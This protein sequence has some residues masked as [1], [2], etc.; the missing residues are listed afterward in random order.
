MTTSLI[1]IQ[2]RYLQL[3]FGPLPDQVLARGVRLAGHLDGPTSEAGSRLRPEDV[4]RHLHRQFYT[5][6]DLD[7]AIQDL[8]EMDRTDPRVKRIHNR[9]ARAAV[10]GGLRLDT[11]SANKRLIKAWKQF[12]KKLQL[13]RPAK[14]HSDFRGLM[15]EGNLPL[16]V[17]LDGDRR[18]AALVRMPT[19]T[20]IPQVGP[21]GRFD[22]PRHAYDQV[23]LAQGGVIGKF[24]LWQLILV[25]LD[26]D[27]FDDLGSLGRPYLDASRTIWRKLSMTEED[28]VIR[29]RMRA[30]LR[31]SHVLEGANQSEME[32]YQH[33]VRSDQADGATTDYFANRK[34]AVTALQ[35]DANLDQIADIEYLLDTF[36]TAAPAPKGLFGY[37]GDLPRDVLEDLKKDYYDELDAMQD[38]LSDAYQ[39][40]FAFDLLLQ[41]IDPERFDHRVQF[42]ERCTETAN[43]RADLALKHQA[44][45]LPR[46]H[47]WRAAGADPAAVRQ[48]LEAE[49][50]ED[51]PYLEPMAEE[52]PGATNRPRVNVT[53][54][55]ARKGESATTIATRSGS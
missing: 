44:L 42:A 40:A 50:K 52:T 55:N 38:V 45:G 41:G 3:G 12:E 29:R 20:I 49:A 2:Q 4:Y 32:A 25:R 9:T 15:M 51:A 21:N 26:P 14:L 48:Q 18:V 28:L 47:V 33:Q 54:S 11:S 7:A 1:K 39:Q 46:E 5:D 37:V 19:E 35:G 8:R 6:P 22:D 24:A 27:N 16:Q 36:F 43:Q 13:D 10:K 23:D 31:M 53:P 30:P 34:G 17:V